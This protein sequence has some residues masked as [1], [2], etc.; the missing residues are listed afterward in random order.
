MAYPSQPRFLRNFRSLGHVLLSILRTIP[1]NITTYVRLTGVIASMHRCECR[2]A[3]PRIPSISTPCEILQRLSMQLS[4]YFDCHRS[5]GS[6]SSVCRPHHQPSQ[7]DHALNRMTCRGVGARHSEVCCC[8]RAF[9]VALVCS[10]FKRSIVIMEKELDGSRWYCQSIS[11]AM[12]AGG[13]DDVF[14]SYWLCAY[15]CGHFSLS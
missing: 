9:N 15:I 5:R 8:F 7:S 3:C 11:K 10:I 4:A 14:V 13:C 12:C 1:L 6:F 2:G